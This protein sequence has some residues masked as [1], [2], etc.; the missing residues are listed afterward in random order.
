MVSGIAG[1]CVAQSPLGLCPQNPHYF[2][3]RG[4][5]TILITSAEHYGAVINLD[6]DYVRYLDELQAC[7][8]NHT[9]LWVGTYREIGGSFA[10]SDNTLAPVAGRYL[11][12]W[13]RSQ[14]PGDCDGGNKFDLTRW[15]EAYFTRL[16][17][18]LTQASRRDIV[19][20]VNLFCP[21]YDDSLWKADPMNAANNVNGVGHC[22]G[23]EV[24]AL[25]HPELTGVQEAV[26][27][28]LV[29]ELRD[30]DNI[31]YEVCNE[32]YFGGVT[33]PWQ[34]HIVAVIAAAEK[35]L[36]HRHLIS[37]NVANGSAKVPD[38]P[39]EVSVFN[40]HYAEPGVVALNYGLGKVIGENETGFRG[41]GDTIYRCG[42]WDFILQG[43]AIYNNLD[44]S[45]SVQHP[46]GHWRN[47]SAPGGGSHDLRLQLKVLKDFMDGFDFV[48]MRPDDAV[49]KGGVPAGF[50]ARA[51]VQAGT[52]YALYIR[53]QA[54][55]KTPDGQQ[56]PMRPA[57]ADEKT[58]A[59]LELDIPKGN[60]EL[61]W[62]A[63][64]TGA[65][66]SRALR[67][68]GGVARLQSPAFGDDV[69]LAIKSAGSKP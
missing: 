34:H 69:A 18:F 11:A 65:R 6:F 13:A 68:N 54:P 47:A 66:Q 62:V 44:Y 8:L 1:P 40:F 59:T 26:T 23:K 42:G 22:G 56:P 24:Y 10:I 14:T 51:L 29:G 16:K 58:R 12:P 49:V 7:G 48:A 64:L 31:Y 9:R 38:P 32:P 19:V 33:I 55:E 25:K 27:R 50:T 41:T 36:P 4:K 20:E 52:Q 63:P 35:P 2:L 67:H 30:F 15:D 45:F 37:M 61:Q 39:A 46:D 21:F 60:Y 28:K 3:V 5:P 53:R 17:D 43:G 57:G